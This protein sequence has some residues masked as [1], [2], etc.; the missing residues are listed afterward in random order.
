MQGF[1]SEVLFHGG[2]R[3]PG[4]GLGRSQ[5]FGLASVSAQQYLTNLQSSYIQQDGSY[6]LNTAQATAGVDMTGIDFTAA[7]T[8]LQQGN[9][10]AAYELAALA[11]ITWEVPVAGLIVSGFIELINA[12]WSTQPTPCTIAGCE[13][14]FGKSACEQFDNGNPFLWASI[15]DSLVPAVPPGQPYNFSNAPDPG[16]PNLIDWGSYDWQDSTPLDPTKPG[17]P[18][19]FEQAL[20][21]T[22][23]ALWD[24]LASA[25]LICNAIQASGSD[26]N[27]MAESGNLQGA[28]MGMLTVNAGALVPLFLAWW[29]A[30]HTTGTI[31]TEVECTQALCQQA[32]GNW[33]GNGD[34]GA[35]GSM[36]Y[37]NTTA[38]APQRMISHVSGSGGIATLYDPL[39][40]AFESLAQ[41][42]KI[43]PSKPLVLL[44]NSGPL[45]STPPPHVV[46]HGPGPGTVVHLGPTPPAAPATSVATKVVVGT[47]LAAGVAAGGVAAYSAYQGESFMTTLKRLK[48]W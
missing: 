45:G 9:Y 30:N 37:C 6:V 32:G 13:Q 4:F 36:V 15:A 3:V 27:L 10:G 28:V 14:T 7:M 11:A 2:R 47:A 42:M 1:G 40:I 12:L 33:Y 44:V 18:G 39:S 26:G 17:G 22:M 38:L 19:S 8:A 34:C 41:L 23:M 46:F 35:G 16:P 20:E 24:K 31:S 21:L 29:N 25:P 5:R 48:F 43:P